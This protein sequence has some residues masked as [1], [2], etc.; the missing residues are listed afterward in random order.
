V[1]A[2]YNDNTIHQLMAAAP[3]NIAQEVTYHHAGTVMSLVNARA[4]NV[5]L[6][7]L[8]ASLALL[9]LSDHNPK[10]PRNLTPPRI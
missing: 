5:S 1:P 2:S 10:S 4:I 9:C 3:E 8:A 6:F 7:V